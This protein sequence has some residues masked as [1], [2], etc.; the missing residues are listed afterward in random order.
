[1]M[2]GWMGNRTNELRVLFDRAGG[3]RHDGGTNRSVEGTRSLLVSG[4]LKARGV[5]NQERDRAL[6]KNGGLR[7]DG[8]RATSPVNLG[9]PGKRSAKGKE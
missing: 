8:S 2:T 1:M 5:G 9:S 4:G 6:Q 7:R 3:L